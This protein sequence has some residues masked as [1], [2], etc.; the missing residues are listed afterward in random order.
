MAATASKH[1]QSQ[2]EIAAQLQRRRKALGMSCQTLAQR[3]GISL[4]TI[5]RM[6]RDGGTHATYAALAAVAQSLGMDFELKSTT[7]EQTFAEQQAEAKAEVIARMV[8]GTSALESQAVDC[9]AFRQ[10][11]NQTVHE[12]MTGSRRKLWSPM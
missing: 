6:L 7:D 11:V 1:S 10:M 9:N 4:P 2:S 8:Q 3:S 5:Q 12:L